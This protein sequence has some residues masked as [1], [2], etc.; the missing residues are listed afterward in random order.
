VFL[1]TSE[2]ESFG[3]AALEALSCGVPVIGYRVGGVP[4]V[5]TEDVGRL[6]AP[7]DLDALASAVVSI[8]SEPTLRETLG[9]QSR[10]RVLA[11]FRSEPAFEAYERLYERVLAKRGASGA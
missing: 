3:L 2:T 4:A 1:L 8:V 7:F 11:N 10:A 5:V 9:A 6:V